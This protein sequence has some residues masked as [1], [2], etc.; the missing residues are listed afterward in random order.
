MKK[1]VPF[2]S[3]LRFNTALCCS[4]AILLTACGGST[5]DAVNQQLLAE[6]VASDTTQAASTRT[7]DLI[8]AG[9][10]AVQAIAQD[11]PTPDAAASAVAPAALVTAQAE[12][13]APAVANQ[14]AANAAPAAQ[15]AGAPASNEFSLSGYQ[16]QA[17]D[18][19][20]ASPSGAGAQQA[21]QAPAA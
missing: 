11:T 9:P 2:A 18:N 15:A 12:P 16:S 20:A 21:T 5:D 1:T 19:T 14:A 13:V 7:V 3:S 17:E 4:I 8:D 6:T 10:A